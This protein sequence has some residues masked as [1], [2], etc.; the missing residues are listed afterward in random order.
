[1]LK[2][3]IKSFKS[4][5]FKKTSLKKRKKFSP[6]NSK[7]IKPPKNSK[8]TSKAIPLKKIAEKTKSPQLM[9]VGEITHFFSRIQVAVIKLRRS[10]L[11]VGDEIVVKGRVTQFKQKVS[12]LQIESVD[13]PTARK[14][15]LAG[16]KVV[17][18]AHEK[19]KVFKIMK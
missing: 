9:E 4:I 11:S 1:M 10:A 13:V 19:D 6:K 2:K 17:K 14:G 16:L 15:S 7:K 18:P 8:K 3:L 12:S 5:F